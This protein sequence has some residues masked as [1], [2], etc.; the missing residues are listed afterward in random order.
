MTWNLYLQASLWSHLFSQSKRRGRTTLRTDSTVANASKWWFFQVYTQFST[1]RPQKESFT[2]WR[3][4]LQGHVT[5]FLWVFMTWNLCLE[6]YLWSYLS[7][8]ANGVVVRRLDEI[9]WSETQVNDDFLN[10]IITST[11]NP[12]Q[13][14][15]KKESFFKWREWLRDP[16]KTFL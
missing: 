13:R 7:P 9:L 8:K 14:H 11:S 6:A 15:H 12:Y 4:W 1:W 10:F 2:K 16:T 5:N 3:Q